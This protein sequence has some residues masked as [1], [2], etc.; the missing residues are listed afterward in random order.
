MDR[1][2][3]GKLLLGAVPSVFLARIA[4]GERRVLRK[5]HTIYTDVRFSCGHVYREA[6]AGG[7]RR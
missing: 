1:R 6:H 2:K 5:P 7:N 4:A 3:F